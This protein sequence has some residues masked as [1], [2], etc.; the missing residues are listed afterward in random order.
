MTER[1]VKDKERNVRGQ[2]MIVFKTQRP[3]AILRHIT[4]F[5][6]VRSSLTLL[7]QTSLSDAGRKYPQEVSTVDVNIKYFLYLP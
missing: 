5:L 6:S 1:R 7:R 3:L 4:V 2:Q